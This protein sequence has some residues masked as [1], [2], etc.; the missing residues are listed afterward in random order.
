MHVTLM[1]KDITINII[2]I[3]TKKAGKKPLG[4]HRR[5]WKNNM[6]MDLREPGLGSAD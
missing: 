6:R 1:F 4:K 2:S 3:T 5:R